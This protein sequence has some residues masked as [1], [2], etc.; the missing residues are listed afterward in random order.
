MAKLVNAYKSDAIV[1]S[2][3]SP[4]STGL[5]GQSQAGYRTF[6]YFGSLGGGTIRLYSKI[7]GGDLVPIPDSKLNTQK[8]DS[9]G[10]VI[11]QFIFVTSGT[12]Y[13]ELT[14]ATSPNVKVYVA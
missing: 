9:N 8:I 12:I 6:A 7:A 11:Q 1:A 14:G 10:D 5:Q 2:T 13:Y 4:V 3:A